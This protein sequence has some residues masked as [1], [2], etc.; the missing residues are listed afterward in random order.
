MVVIVCTMQMDL[1]LPVQL[2]PITTKAVSSNPAHGEVHSI[3]R[4][5]MFVRDLREVGDF[6]CVLR[7]LHQ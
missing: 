4:Y 7:I 5:M 1:Q 6:L 3:Q 2:V